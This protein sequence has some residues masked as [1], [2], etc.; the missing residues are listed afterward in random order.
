MQDTIAAPEPI[1]SHGAALERVAVPQ[2]LIY[3]DSDAERGS[4]LVVTVSA[5]GVLLDLQH[6]GWRSCDICGVA[7]GCVVGGKWRPSSRGSKTSFYRCY[8]CEGL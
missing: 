6:T 3:P 2:G 8:K 5:R 1:Q 7:T 4:A